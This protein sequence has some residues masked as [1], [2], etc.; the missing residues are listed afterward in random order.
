MA[1]K[2]RV[3]KQLRRA[4]EFVLR[5]EN[6]AAQPI[7]SIPRY[8]GARLEL[9]EI[10]WTWSRPRP[11]GTTV[12]FQRIPPDL[13]L[14]F[15]SLNGAPDEAIVEFAGRWGPLFLGARAERMSEWR[16]YAHLT[17]AI[18]LA[19]G[20]LA[21]GQL[22]EDAEWDFIGREAY[23]DDYTGWKFDSYLKPFGLVAALNKLHS[24]PNV[25]GTLVAVVDGR[26]QLLPQAIGLASAVILQ[27]ARAVAGAP[28]RAMCSACGR[29]FSPTRRPTRGVRQYCARKKCKVASQRHGARDYRE[30]KK[31]SDLARSRAGGPTNNPGK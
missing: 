10:E 20:E 12:S 24:L 23:G 5:R 4:A 16:R 31:Q 2:R 17:A 19:A 26:I 7:Q 21:G 25:P 18:W 15:A 28:V 3:Y 29:A 13:S 6:D 9:G 30:R 27:L 8:Q 22:C 14:Q 1:N 11:S